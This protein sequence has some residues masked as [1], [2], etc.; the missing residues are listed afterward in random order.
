MTINLPTSYEDVRTP[1][2]IPSNIRKL[3][4]L[5][6][7]HI[8]YHSVEALTLALNKM[9]Q[10]GVDG[11]LLNGDILDFYQLSRF[12][13]D[14]R[15]RGFAEELASCRSFLDILKSEFDTPIY[16]KMG[17][18]EERYESYMK[19]KAPEIFGVRDFEIDILLRLGEKRI[20]FIT[21]KR[22]VKAGGLS[23]FHGHELNIS[24]GINPARTL[25]LRSQVSSLCGHLHVPSHHSE[26]RADGHIVGCWS[27]GHLGEVSPDYAP[28]NKWQHGF[29]IVQL[30]GKE[31]EVNNYKIMKGKVFRG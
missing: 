19:R 3:A 8:P 14:P 13:K 4:V 12:E 11:I 23:I 28:Y 29:A 1:F 6:D 27:T 5:S 31:F 18:H 7:I 30:S 24:G 2:Q 9:Q 26:K 22:I 16:F 10:E 15:K 25:F 17:N 20:E 21:D